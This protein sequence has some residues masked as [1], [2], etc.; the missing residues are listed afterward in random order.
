MPS[1][2]RRRFKRVLFPFLVVSILGRPASSR[3]SLQQFI[4]KVQMF[5][6][7]RSGPG[8]PS[9]RLLG[10]RPAVSTR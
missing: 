7:R 8:E 6:S 1:A 2:R 9:H 3:V 4:L 5:H 10:R